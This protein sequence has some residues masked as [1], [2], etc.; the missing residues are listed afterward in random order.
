MK[1]I[2]VLVFL[3]LV[4]VALIFCG[5]VG[6]RTKNSHLFGEKFQKEEYPNNSELN[7]LEV[8]DVIGRSQYK[9]KEINLRKLET[10]DLEETG[11]GCFRCDVSKENCTVCYTEFYPSELN[12]KFSCGICPNYCCSCANSTHCD[13]C[14]SSYYENE[15]QCKKCSNGCSDCDN[16]TTCKSCY[17]GYYN[18]E[19]KC[20]KCPKICDGCDNSTACTDCNSGYYLSKGECIECP[21]N[22]SSCYNSTTCGGCAD[23]YDL[24][25]GQCIKCPD[26]CSS[27]YNSTT[28]GGCDSG[29]DLIDGQCIKCADNCNNCINSTT[30]GGCYS[31]YYLIDGQCSNC[32]N[33]CADC[34][35]STSCDSCNIGYFLNSLN[36]C[37][38][39]L[40]TK[41]YLT[42]DYSSYSYQCKCNSTCPEGF[43]PYFSYSSYFYCQ[44]CRLKSYNDTD[45]KCQS[46]PS[47]CKSCDSFGNCTSCDNENGGDS[48]TLFLE[49]GKCL[50]IISKGCL[51]WFYYHNDTGKCERCLNGYELNS[52]GNCEKKTIPD[53]KFLIYGFNGYT[54]YGK[55]F[56][57]N[58]YA[59]VVQGLMYESQ[60]MFDYK[61]TK[62]DNQNDE[63]GS[64]ICIQTRFAKGDGNID[65]GSYSCYDYGEEN[66]NNY[67]NSY[68]NDYNEYNDYFLTLQCEGNSNNDINPNDEITITNI[69]LTRLN[70]EDVSNG[71]I[72]SFNLLNYPL[73]N[74]S[75]LISSYYSFHC[76]K[77]HKFV[78]DT[79]NCAI[80]N[81]DSKNVIISFTGTIIDDEEISNLNFIIPLFELSSDEPLGKTASCIL[82]KEA[83]K[84][85][86]TMECTIENLNIN[87]F[88]LTKEPIEANDSNFY[89]IYLTTYIENET[90]YCAIEGDNSKDSSSG[91]SGGAIA[92]IVIGSVVGAGIIVGGVVIGVTTAT[93]AAGTSAGAG[94]STATAAAM[95]SSTA[96]AI[97]SNPTVSS[98]ATAK[99]A[100]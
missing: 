81:N 86:S 27:C 9:E 68:Y 3:I 67:Y 43:R 6:K 69:K 54:S 75:G 58:I 41:P 11:N 78:A 26:N 64:G 77:W 24:I 49:D 60:I 90:I 99:L 92:G 48:S 37:D 15:G 18:N 21:D 20:Y 17:Y 8:S 39:C 44:N 56:G 42:C 1:K 61:I 74:R 66:Y 87:S 10:C 23:G 5:S 2:E 51:S 82:N 73:N 47:V 13:K 79:N 55:V 85:N 80:L 100:G 98:V 14:F 25:D 94:A 63:T 52:D 93:A 91:L 33:G 65:Y 53:T 70:K 12:N 45:G 83:N 40:P 95:S 31:G 97:S 38:N 50:S 89:G 30:C 88:T 32:S 4:N 16:S 28:C 96:P 19:G 72:Q 71:N 35:N 22:C 59:V 36:Q 7:N 76:S 84:K 34:K 46:C 29:Y 62:Y 57:F